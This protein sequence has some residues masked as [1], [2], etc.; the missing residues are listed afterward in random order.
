MLVVKRLLNAA[1]LSYQNGTVIC[2]TDT[3]L[4]KWCTVLF[5]ADTFVFV[6]IYCIYI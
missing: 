6:Y 5:I 4:V 1:I 2:A 3:V